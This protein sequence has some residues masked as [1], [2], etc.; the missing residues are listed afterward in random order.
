MRI[1]F[2][3][4]VFRRHRRASSIARS[5]GG[6]DDCAHRQIHSR[7]QPDGVRQV[8]LFPAT[9]DAAKGNDHCRQPP[10]NGDGRSGLRVA[11]QEDTGNPREQRPQ[12]RREGNPILHG[13]GARREVPLS[14][15]RALL[16]SATRGPG[17]P[18]P[19]QAKYM[20]VDEAHCV[21]QWGRDFRPEY[22][23]L[24]EVRQSLGSPP[25]LAFTAT[26]GLAMQKRILA[27]LG[28]EDATVLVRGVD[29]P[30]IAL[31]RWLRR[32]LSSSGD[33]D[34]CACRLKQGGKS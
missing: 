11:P 6:S 22:G 4:G 16:R 13:R 19:E 34:C 26:A 33:R 12:S 31:I 3:E 7:R 2:N 21:D 23:R 24:R 17:H 25:I 8:S 1:V 15:A 20:V 28:I 18:D 14:S 10:E 5:M 30:N 27:S 9:R 32:F 29:R